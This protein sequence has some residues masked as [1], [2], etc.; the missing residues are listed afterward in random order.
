MIADAIQVPDGLVFVPGDV[1]G[2]RERVQ[3]GPP[4]A[5]PAIRLG[6]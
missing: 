1:K 2:F 5:L 6:G 4:G 3:H